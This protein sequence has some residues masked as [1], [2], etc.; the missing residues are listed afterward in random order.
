M[1]M[2]PDQSG[3]RWRNSDEDEISTLRNVVGSNDDEKMARIP[4]MNI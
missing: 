1:T 4:H 2:Y 3:P